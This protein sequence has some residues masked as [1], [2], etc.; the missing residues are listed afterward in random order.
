M[1]RIREK[2]LGQEKKTSFRLRGRHIPEE[3]IDRYL[4]RQ[5]TVVAH[6]TTPDGITVTSLI[7]CLVVIP[8][9]TQLANTPPDIEYY[10]PSESS[11]TPETTGSKS[12][13]MA[14]CRL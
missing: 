6:P 2:R 10:T 14:E 5:K 3:Q 13:T 11:T 1:I 7:K 9:L 8:V 4:K 12:S